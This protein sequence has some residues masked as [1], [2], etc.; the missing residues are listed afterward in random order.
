MNILKGG[1]VV[2]IGGAGT[3][4]GLGRGLVRHFAAKGMRVAIL[5]REGDAA[6]ALAT[7]LRAEGIDAISCVVDVA[8]H[9][10]L[11][12]A[13]ETVGGTF[14]ACNVLCAH[15]GTGGQGRFEQTPISVWRQAYEVMVIGVVASVQAFLPLMRSTS[16]FRRIVLTSSVAALAPGRFQGPYRA[17]KAAVTSIGET[18]DLEFGP[19]GIGATVIFPSGMADESLI[20]GSLA[21]E[22]AR[23]QAARRRREDPV[24]A[25][26]GEE[27][28]RDPTDLIAGQHAAKPVV[29]AVIAGQRYVITHGRTVA[30]Y[31]AERQRLLD[32]AFEDLARREYLPGDP[33]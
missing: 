7:E 28:N 24:W 25:A 19:Q 11:R 10:S 9:E 31:S 33:P 12:A 18:L 32:Q 6:A 2:V 17:A 29:D 20:G 21:E 5:D 8:N 3:G 14:N 30:G 15:V 26:I 4:A 13:A 27:L 1:T 22:N 23:A 16:G